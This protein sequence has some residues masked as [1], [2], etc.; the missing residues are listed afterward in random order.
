MFARRP[1][2]A[3]A[4]QSTAIPVPE[5]HC[6]PTHVRELSDNSLGMERV[7]LL[8]AR[9]D[10]H[11]GHLFDDGPK[12]TGLRYCINSSSLEFVPAK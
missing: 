3:A 2:R 7:E 1:R 4:G 11:L 5:R 6:N 10:G 8:C 9:C 12:P